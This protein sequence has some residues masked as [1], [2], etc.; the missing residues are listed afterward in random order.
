MEKETTQ[1]DNVPQTDIENEEA[2]PGIRKRISKDEI[3]KLP[4]ARFN[5]RV[6]II[7]T[8]DAAEIAVDRLSKSKVLGFDTE[9]RPS[10]KKGDNFPPSIVQFAG[11][12]EAFIFQIDRL[13]GLGC[14]LSL[15]QSETI[16][17]VGVALHDDVKRLKEIEDFEAAGFGE[18]N[19]ISKR[20]GVSN[21]GLRSLVALFLDKR[22]SKGAQ[23]SNWAKK[24]LSQSQISYAATDAWISREL[25]IKLHEVALEH[26]LLDGKNGQ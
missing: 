20:I 8:S 22:V 12:E 13:G 26:N 5:G 2:L 18:I 11:E 7:T 25:Y 6:S 14:I 15:L 19:V 1:T 4:L 23:I 10:F 9:S 3:N 17:K 21:T 16:T 24:N